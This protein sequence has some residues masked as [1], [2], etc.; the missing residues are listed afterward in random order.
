M[1]SNIDDKA[2]RG[3]AATPQNDA[4]DSNPDLQGEGNYT[5]TRRYRESV[6]TF[7]EEGKVKDAAQA[8][9]PKT[10]AQRREMQ[11]AES[12]AKSHARK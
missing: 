10:E 5:A 1:N 8:A 6:E 2:G 9:A 12:E 4:Q 11:A 3:Q 7:V